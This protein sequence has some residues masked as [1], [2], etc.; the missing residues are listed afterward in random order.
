M[1]FGRKKNNYDDDYDDEYDDEED[2][3]L[4][5]FKGALNDTEVDLSQH[6]RLVDAGLMRA[7]DLVTDAILRRAELIRVE[8]RGER[9]VIQITVDGIGYPGGKLSKQEALAI[10]QMMKLLAGL[11]IR[12]RKAPQS[13]GLVSELEEKKYM[14]DVQT[15]PLQGGAERLTI[16]I[17][18]AS[19]KLETPEEVGFSPELKEKL[20]DMSGERSGVILAAG[21]PR[22][23][24]TTTSFAL[25]RGLDVYL[26]S[27]Y[28]ICNTGGR[29]LSN[30]TP[31]EVKKDDDLKTTI[32]RCMRVDA[33]VIMCDPIKG[34]DQAR[35]IF[36]L[37]D[38]VTLMSEITA[39][40]AIGGI[41]QLVKYL[42]DPNIVANGLRGIFSQKLLRKLCEDCKE[43]FR[44][45]PKLIA[46]AGLPPET[47]VLY[48]APR[49]DDE[50]P[51]Y[52]PCEHCGGVG[53]H[54]RMAMIEMV[55]MTDEMKAALIG[56]GGSAELKAVARK[57]KMPTFRQEGLR[58][59]AEGITSLEEL[60]RV[61][62]A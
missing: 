35:D 39:R 28:T 49:F 55:E 54:G 15:T 5:A 13:G 60:Q 52:E 43:A 61:F 6:G 10:T 27:I 21:P 30:I 50:D 42:E 31:F 29:E 1:I 58:M 23:G 18:D 9:A 36:E 41:I 33:D 53:Y 12:Q 47:K 16:G 20:R 14:L 2:Y 48:R 8:P 26:Y 45:N 4:V 37:C 3:E 32:Q 19:I 34:A 25:L 11:D 51:E 17:R 22:S 59:V 44:P 62:K 38:K 56:G 24:T 7:K 40:D 57:E 46:K